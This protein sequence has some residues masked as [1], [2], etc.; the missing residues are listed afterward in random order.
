M[1]ACKHVGIYNV[2][3]SHAYVDCISFGVRIYLYVCNS[4]CVCVYLFVCVCVCA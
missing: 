4:M 3:M 1:H 2:H